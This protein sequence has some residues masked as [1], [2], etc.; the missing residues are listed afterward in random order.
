M[1]VFLWI[2]G[3]SMITMG[4]AWAARPDQLAEWNDTKGPKWLREFST[5]GPKPA[6]PGRTSPGYLRFCGVLFF[7]M[8]ALV[9][10]LGFAVEL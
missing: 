5:T 9:V 2:L 8:G 3:L 1:R 6:Y 7:S 10:Y 4:G